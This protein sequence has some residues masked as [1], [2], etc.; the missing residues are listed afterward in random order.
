MRQDL[1]IYYDFVLI[2]QQFGIGDISQRIK[3]LSKRRETRTEGTRPCATAWV[4]VILTI[5]TLALMS[6]PAL[7]TRIKR[8]VEVCDIICHQGCN[9]NNNNKNITITEM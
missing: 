7:P 4:A 1:V 9:N 6:E 8:F 2:M 3:S 5:M